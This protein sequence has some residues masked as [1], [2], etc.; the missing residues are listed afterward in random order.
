MVCH[1]VCGPFIH[2]QEL[3]HPCVE[4]RPG[5]EG[6]SQL[7]QHKGDGCLGWDFLVLQKEAAIVLYVIMPCWVN[8]CQS[9]LMMLLLHYANCIFEAL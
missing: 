6:N 4:Q 1:V 3:Q 2:L 8:A 7:V 5:C 9:L